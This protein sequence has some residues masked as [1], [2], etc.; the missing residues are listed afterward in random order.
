VAFA[1]ADE[2]ARQRF[3]EQRARNSGWDEMTFN[4]SNPKDQRFKAFGILSRHRKAVVGT[5]KTLSTPC[6]L[7]DALR[8]KHAAHPTIHFSVYSP[9]LQFKL[10]QTFIDGIH[11]RNSA[12]EKQWSP[13]ITKAVALQ[14]GLR[15]DPKWVAD[16]KVLAD[17]LR[18]V[19][20]RA[21]DMI[22]LSAL[23]QGDHVCR[24]ATCINPG[25]LQLVPLAENSRR[26]SMTVKD[27]N[28]TQLCS[29]PDCN[30]SV[31][32]QFPDGFNLCQPC[33]GDAPTTSWIGEQFAF[34]FA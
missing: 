22:E 11:E 30:L 33:G 21:R 31:S 9:K 5:L 29:A 34:S 14:F 32:S 10:P 15:L 18:G 24:N 4:C 12:R 23:V 7:R 3:G 17:M 25:H 20:A 1:D 2:A 13:S 8:H 6:V 28:S 19:N 16:P 27:A 26:S